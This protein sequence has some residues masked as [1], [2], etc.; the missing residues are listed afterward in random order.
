VSERGREGGRREGVFTELVIEEVQQLH[1]VG[2]GVG[3]GLHSTDTHTYTETYRDRDTHT[4]RDRD[5][6]ISSSLTRPHTQH[7]T[8][9]HN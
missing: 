8:A 4:D 7:S 3:V 6:N 5:M 9:Q 1:G 2:L